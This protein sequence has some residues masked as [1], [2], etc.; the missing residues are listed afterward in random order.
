MKKFYGEIFKLKDYC[1]KLG[2]KYRFEHLYNGYTI[3]FQEKYDIVQHDHSYG[4]DRGCVEFAISKPRIDYRAISLENAKRLVHK[5]KDY[6]N[7][8]QR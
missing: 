3:I 8:V 6:L 5:Y 1:D 4:N 7:E 2:I